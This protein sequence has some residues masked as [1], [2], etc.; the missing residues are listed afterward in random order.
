MSVST[1][2]LQGVVFNLTPV[3]ICKDQASET[4]ERCPHRILGIKLRACSTS[5]RENRRKIVLQLQTI[6]WYRGPNSF[7]P[8]A[9]REMDLKEAFLLGQT[10]L[11]FGRP[12]KVRA[13]SQR[14]V[15]SCRAPSLSLT[16]VASIV[17]PHRMAQPRQDK[18]GNLFSSIFA[19]PLHPV[20]NQP[21]DDPSHI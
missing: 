1:P 7:L 6:Y 19:C 8:V 20:R 9:E 16:V 11:R 21:N 14:A 18:S 5:S 3:T 17:R 10:H 13:A 12:M 15:T 2:G 4:R